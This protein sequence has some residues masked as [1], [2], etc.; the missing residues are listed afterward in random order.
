MPHWSEA[1]GILRD[2]KQTGSTMQCKHCGR[3]WEYV[4]GSG[5]QR[6]WCQRCAGPLCGNKLCLEHCLPFEAQLEYYEGKRGSR[7]DSVIQ[8]CLADGAQLL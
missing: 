3:H 1:G 4:P 7:Y 2:G 8:S 5:V 6:G